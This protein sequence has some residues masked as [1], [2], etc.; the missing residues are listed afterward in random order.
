[1]AIVNG[2][3]FADFIHRAG[4]GQTGPGNEISTV[5]VGDDTINADN[6]NDLVYADSGN[7][8]VRGDNGADT[9]NGGAGNDLLYSHFDGG[10][11]EHG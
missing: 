4:D 8:L 5:T 10:F 1:M 6:G 2:T 7:D 11:F 3:Q 9:L